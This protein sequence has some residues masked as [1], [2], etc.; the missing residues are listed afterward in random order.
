MRK[1]PSAI[2]FGAQKFACEN[3][4]LEHDLDH[5]NYMG[6]NPSGARSGAQ[7]VAYEEPPSGTR[8]RAQKIT[9]KKTDLEHDLDHK[10]YIEKKIWSTENLLEWV[11]FSEELKAR[12]I[13][14]FVQIQNISGGYFSLPSYLFV[15]KTKKNTIYSTKIFTKKYAVLKES[16]ASARAKWV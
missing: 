4:H 11:M 13:T 16:R 3:T 5:K 10:N 9:R 6:K 15:I 1:D 14:G 2:R 7:K 12:H 8:F